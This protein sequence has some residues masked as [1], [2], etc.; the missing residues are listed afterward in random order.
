MHV[1]K[2]RLLEISVLVW[3]LQGCDAS[4]KH[5]ISANLTWLQQE[6]RC[7]MG[8]IGY[9]GNHWSRPVSSCCCVEE[10]PCWWQWSEQ[11]GLSGWSWQKCCSHSVNHSLQLWWAGKHPNDHV[12]RRRPHQVVN[13]KQKPETALDTDSPTLDC[14]SLEKCWGVIHGSN[15]AGSNSG[16]GCFLDALWALNTNKCFEYHSLSVLLSMATVF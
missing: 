15:L 13:R 2:L 6:C 8:W 16:W 9:F 5:L 10:T 11:N 3:K 1:L 12:Q 14:S 7:Q 4:W